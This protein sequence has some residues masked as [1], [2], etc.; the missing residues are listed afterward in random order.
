MRFKSWIL[1][2][3]LLLA[4]SFQAR[5]QFIDCTKGLLMMP[6]AEMEPSGTFMITNNFLN[7]SYVVNPN[8]YGTYWGYNTFSYGFGITF[9]SRLEIDYVCTLMV[10]AWSPYAQTY[11]AKVMK[12]QDRHFAARFQVLKENEFGLKWL[13]SIVMGLSDPVTGGRKDYLDDS[14]SSK[15]KNGFF[16]RYYIAASK[17]FDTAWGV[18]GAHIAYQTTKRIYLIPKGPQFGL[19]WNP[20]WINKPGSFLSSFRII[21]E[22]DAQ[23]INLGATASIWK[24]HFEFWTCLQDCRH[25]NGGLRFKV[26]LAGAE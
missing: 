3:T 5:S 2:L 26:V 7:K 24:D 16:N 18:V 23:Q 8:H 12:N 15:T 4:C 17:H 9:W 1:V 6:S 11:R 22:Y 14:V 10:G 20:V 19:T 13:P 25:F 21:A